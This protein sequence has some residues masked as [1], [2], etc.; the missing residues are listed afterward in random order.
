[1]SK[2]AARVAELDD[3]NLMLR[4]QADDPEAFG[5]L[6]DR[7]GSRAYRVAYAIA[8]DSS[9]AEDVVQEAFLSI[10]RSRASYQPGRGAVV[11]WVLGTVRNRAIDSGR[12]AG[13]H[14]NRRSDDERIEETLQAPGSLEQTTVERD[15]AARLRGALAELPDAQREVIALAYF[16]ELSTSEIAGELA[17]PMGTIKGRMRLGLQKLRIA[18]PH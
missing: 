3:A 8:R 12:R 18:E 2:T 7:F 9:R 10:W 11:A 15:Q 16:G 13:R 17:L 1:M 14:D 6:Y 5:A 4:V